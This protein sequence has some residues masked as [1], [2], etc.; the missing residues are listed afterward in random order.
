MRRRASIRRK[1]P[2]FPISALRQAVRAALAKPNPIALE[3][4]NAIAAYRVVDDFDLGILMHV[5]A[6]VECAF[7]VEL[8]ERAIDSATNAVVE[9]NGNVIM[10]DQ[11]ALE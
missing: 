5:F 11:A 4:E 1:L 3:I 8:E 9:C 10:L 2:I 6:R 7:E